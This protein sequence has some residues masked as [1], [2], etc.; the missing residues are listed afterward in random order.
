MPF[1]IAF[2]WLDNA[3]LITNLPTF[4]FTNFIFMGIHLALIFTY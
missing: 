2:D 4:R 1:T 3:K